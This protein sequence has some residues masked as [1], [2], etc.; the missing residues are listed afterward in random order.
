MFNQEIWRQRVADR[1]GGFAR[2]PRQDV[3]IAGTNSVLAYLAVRTLEPFL[4][5]F[6]AEPVGAVLALAEI[7]RGP[8]ADQIVR[9]ASQMRYQVSQLIERELRISAD[10]RAA[11]EQILVHLGVIH[12]ARQRLNSTRDEWLRV[13]LLA[14]LDNYS[15]AEFSQLRRLLHDPGWQSRYETIRSLRT[16]DGRYSAADLVLLHDGLGDSASHVRAAA[17]RQLGQ[18]AGTPPP[19]LV[20]ALTRVALYD[21]DLE[22]RFAAARTLGSL[23]DRIAS[24]QLIDHLGQ[25]LADEDNF[26]RSAAALAL[27]QLGELAG[28]ADMISK[29]AALVSDSDPYTREAAARALGK[30]GAAAATSSVLNALARAM[31]DPDANVHEAAID[32]L[33]RLRKI[34]ATMP[35][36]ST[37]HPSEPLTV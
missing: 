17:A 32:S 9:R 13:T 7:N 15:P 22:T 3:Q 19:P 36:S 6:Q 37:R 14:E 29:L 26:V 2:N 10:L 12:M 24:P 25:C 21:C 16:R 11:V 35:L 23:R 1:L 5:A 30:I 18:F 20:K 31:E 28:T 27:G 34:R 8:G 33:T 4:E